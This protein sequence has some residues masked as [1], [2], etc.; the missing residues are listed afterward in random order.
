MADVS[1]PAPFRLLASGEEA[2]AAMLEAIAG[3]R[4]SIQFEMYIW[5]DDEVGRRFLVAL[6]EAR[7]RGVSVQLLVDAWGSFELNRDFFGILE[8]AGAQVRWFNPIDLR[9]FAFRDHRKLLVCD[10]RIAFIGGFNVARE[11]AGD[12]RTRGWCDVGLALTGPL[13][14]ELSAAF[15]EMFALAGLR[16]RLLAPLRRSPAKR[17]RPGECCELLLSG[18]GR[19]CN[20]IKAALLREFNTARHSIQIVSA[21]FLPPRRMRRALRRAVRRGVRVQLLLAGRSDV[22]LSQQATRSLYRRFLRA[23][24]ELYEYQPQ[25]LHAKLVVAD[26]AVFTGSSNLDPRSL[27]FNYELLVRVN[28]PA[29]TAAAREL[30]HRWRQ[31]SRQIHLADWLR[32]RSWC[33]RLRQRWAHFVVTQL[34]RFVSHRQLRRLR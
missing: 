1:R 12:G 29:L 13:V 10:D 26:H 34:D 15:T 28:D 21:Y 9:R 3:A 22:P 20:P 14:E 7:Q 11:Y 32:E 30:F 8:R 33:E 18:P 25:I 2:F 5:G 31:D 24:F 6:L 17:R 16:H 27:D 19:G 4:V 23:G